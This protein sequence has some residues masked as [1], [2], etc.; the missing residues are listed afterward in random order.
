M[1]SLV[2]RGQMYLVI[3]VKF[4]F[5]KDDYLIRTLHRKTKFGAFW[6]N[7]KNSIISLLTKVI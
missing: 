5:N 2:I 7:E 4:C 6:R 1:E 3:S